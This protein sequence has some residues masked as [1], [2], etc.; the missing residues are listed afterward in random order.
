MRPI[1][2]S[3]RD[4]LA[5]SALAGTAT[6]AAPFVRGAH[7]AGRLSC[8]FWDHWVPGANDTLT[9]LC[10]EWG[11]RERVDVAIDYITS[12]GEKNRLTIMSESQART[13]HDVLAMATWYPS[14]QANNLVPVDDVVTALIAEHGKPSPAVEY[15]G[16]VKGHWIAVPATAG[17]QAKPPCARLDLFKQHVG[18]DPREMYPAG[19][20][21]NPAMTEMWT[22]DEFLRAA[23]ACHKAGYPFGM[24]LSHLSDSVDWTGAVFAAHGA[25]LVDVEG[26]I[27]VNS[28]ATR[29]VLEWFKQLVP[30]LPPDVVAWDDAGNNKWLVSGK[31]ALI[32]NPPSAWAVAKRDAPQIAEQLWTFGA[33]RGP[34]GRYSPFLPYYWGI[35]N[36]SP[37]QS[38]AK[39]LLTHLS[40][41]E[42]VERLVAASSGYDIPAFEKLH[43]FPTW[44]EQGPPTG[45]IY[46]YPPRGDQIPSVAAAPAPPT[47]ANQIYTQGTMT[48]MAARCT[49]GGE[50][51]ERT[52]AWATDELA[53]FMR[54]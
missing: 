6:V 7:A 30:L 46:H 8:G 40:R 16:K 25:Q 24:P 32:M 18:W 17:S 11:E 21:P 41:R 29:Q 39:S 52:I 12:Q 2:L 38:A 26:K 15:L 34:I 33:P 1:G 42:S 48:K 19:A 45:T 36:F 51:V 47:I 20:P 43:D 35:W 50:S 10:R 5:R 53:G 49:Q 54:I 27:T 4:F 23:A 31:G 3:R 44:R 9:K 37:N 14:D 22:W 28:D 13:G